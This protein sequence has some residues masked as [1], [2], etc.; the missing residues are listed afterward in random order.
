LRNAVIS[1]VTPQAPDGDRRE[2]FFDLIA[3]LTVTQIRLLKFVADPSGW[4][5]RTQRQRPR[6][7][8]G[9]WLTVAA[10]MPELAHDKDVALAYYDGLLNARLVNVTLDGGLA[11]G[12]F[13]EPATTVLGK[14]FLKFI[15]D[16]NLAE[17]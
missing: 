5:E 17:P 15:E 16:P 7:Q 6:A 2:L 12:E 11:G 3:R 9:R 10:A 4:F 8:S 1:S 14:Q 13:E